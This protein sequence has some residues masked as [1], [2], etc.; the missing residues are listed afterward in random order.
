M[1]AES[2]QSNYFNVLQDDDDGEDE[3]ECNDCCNAHFI[4]DTTLIDRPPNTNI[5]GEHMHANGH[6][7]VY[8]AFN[9]DLGSIEEPK[10]QKH[11]YQSKHK[12][13]F[14]AAE[15]SELAGLDDMNTFEYVSVS[16]LPRVPG[17]K[18]NI[19]NCIWRYKIKPDR[20][21]ARIC[22]NGA[23]QR[24][25]D[26]GD[27]F[28]PVCRF[29]T[30]RL[31]LILAM[32]KGWV[33]K[34]ADIKQAFV[35]APVPD[36]VNIYVSCPPGYARPGYVMRCKKYCYG[37]H[38]SPTAFNRYFVDWITSQG[39]KQSK[40]DECLFYNGEMY[41]C[42]YVDDILY[43]GSDKHVAEFLVKLKKKFAITDLGTAETF[44]GIEIECTAETVVLHQRKYIETILNRF[45]MNSTNIKKTPM[46]LDLKLQ[47]MIGECKDKTMQNA[48]RQKVGALLYLASSTLPTISYVVKELSRHLQHPTAQH[49]QACNRVFG[50]LRH[51][52]QTGEYRLTYRNSGSDLIGACD[53]SWA[54]IVESARSTSGVLFMLC[55]AVLTW[56]SQTQKCVTH[57]STESEYVALDS[58]VRELEYLTML[59][60]EFSMQVPKPC[61]ILEDSASCMK[62]TERSVHHQ[63]TKHINVRYHCVRDLV[64]SGNVRIQHQQT[65]YQPAD[66][67]TKQLGDTKQQRF[68]WYVLGL[69]KLDLIGAKHLQ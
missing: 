4:P 27:V 41:V 55:G 56:S 69:K 1:P 40:I 5:V 47:K 32:Q 59:M 33:V 21:K 16:E 58:A 62:L 6:K 22:I 19:L 9:I 64:K 60:N 3:S 20:V 52:L 66:L 17:K 37:L 53:A 54:D 38:E 31:L 65:D 48:Y 46:E 51:I 7:Q 18:L 28:V 8:Y 29:V 15:K 26:Y 68:A 2:M 11:A 42:L 36:D 57:S 35:N 50:Y 63:R 12:S 14:V 43:T 30:F 23:R 34:Q 49:M 13:L 44:L 39:F 24:R 45:R 10:S 67:L 61:T 25:E